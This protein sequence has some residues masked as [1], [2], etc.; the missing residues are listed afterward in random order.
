MTGRTTAVSWEQRVASRTWQDIPRGYYA[1]EIL[2]QPCECLDNGVEDECGHMPELLGYRLFERKES[3]VTR[4][5]RR[6]GKDRFISGTTVVV[7]GIDHDLV[8]EVLDSERDWTTEVWG[9]RGHE[10]YILDD[11]VTK[12]D[13]YRAQYGKFTGRCG[14]CGRALTDNDSKLRGIGPECLKGLQP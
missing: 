10:L 2:H 14:C 12:P 9:P 11:L 4:T 3:R 7:P 6:V 1:I 8:R 13:Y 5:G